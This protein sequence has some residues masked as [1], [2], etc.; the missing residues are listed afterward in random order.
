MRI[1]A[2]S[3]TLFALVTAAAVAGPVWGPPGWQNAPLDPSYGP[4]SHPGRFWMVGKW[5]GTGSQQ[6]TGS[7]W[8]I[9]LT[10]S[11]QGVQNYAYRIDYPSLGCGGYWTFNNGDGNTGSFTEHITYG[12]EKCVDLGTI[13]VGAVGGG[14]I[15]QMAYHWSGTQPNGDTDN[16]GATLARTQ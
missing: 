2:L 9:A 12:R 3:I 14:H 4:P 1:I 7:S 15:S 6:Q 13:T 11:D 8:T 16:A 10:V 5:E